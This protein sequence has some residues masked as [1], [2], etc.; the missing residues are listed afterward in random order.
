MTHNLACLDLWIWWPMR[1]SLPSYF[2]CMRQYWWNTLKM[3]IVPR[4]CHLEILNPLSIIQLVHMS[5][6]QCP[7]ANFIMLNK[8]WMKEILTPSLCRKPDLAS[9]WHISWLLLTGQEFIYNL[10]N[11]GEARKKDGRGQHEQVEKNMCLIVYQCN[12]VQIYI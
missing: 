4:L 12:N 5:S 6:Y 8:P 1:C 7:Q 9:S 2:S 3:C 10:N 11:R